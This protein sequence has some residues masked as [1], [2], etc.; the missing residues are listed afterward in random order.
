MKRLLPDSLDASKSKTIMKDPKKK[1][2][3]RRECGNQSD[4]NLDASNSKTIMKDNREAIRNQSDAMLN[5]TKHLLSKEDKNVVISPLSIQLMLSLIASG[6][7]GYTLDQLLSFL[8]S[9]SID[10]LNS[11]ASQ[12]ALAVADASRSGGP[13]LSFANGVW[14][15]KSVSLKPSF[16]QLVD[17]QYK[18]VLAQVNFKTKVRIYMLPFSSHTHY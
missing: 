5:F 17:S 1:R 7:K 11:F 4:M 3:R 2:R 16:K 13:R 14:L 10:H 15:D 8:N 6:S 9:K 12:L 18:A